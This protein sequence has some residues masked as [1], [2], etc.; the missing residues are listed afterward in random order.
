M[1][2]T[3]ITQSDKIKQTNFNFKPNSID[4]KSVQNLVSSRKLLIKKIIIKNW[5]L[6][7]K[8]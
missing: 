6:K 4:R 8:Y 7:K 3:E 1:N 5:K 2:T